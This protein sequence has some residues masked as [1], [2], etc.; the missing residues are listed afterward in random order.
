MG[1]YQSAIYAF[2]ILVTIQEDKFSDEKDK[3]NLE[4]MR[5]LIKTHTRLK[6]D[7]VIIDDDNVDK[8][9]SHLLI[10]DKNFCIESH[11]KGYP[12]SISIGDGFTMMLHN[13]REELSERCDFSKIAQQLHTSPAWHNVFTESH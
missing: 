4:E 12:N 3:Y 10:Y 13:L 5:D 7:K 6:C 9:A 2:G 1:R 8:P 11:T